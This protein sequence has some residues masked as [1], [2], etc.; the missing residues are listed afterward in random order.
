MM[1]GM[2]VQKTKRK[3]M[4]GSAVGLYLGWNG[5]MMTQVCALRGLD[6]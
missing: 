6:D 2:K 4:P 5:G 3:D 1:I